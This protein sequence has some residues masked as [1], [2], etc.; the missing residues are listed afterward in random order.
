MP[1]YAQY[2]HTGKIHSLISVK[3]P[4]G[5][6]AT[7]MMAAKPGLLVAEIEG[8]TFQSD[9]PSVDELRA[10]SRTHKVATPIPKVKLTR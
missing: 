5:K 7:M 6:D 9:P 4:P 2:D 1:T 8:V 3:A 10:I